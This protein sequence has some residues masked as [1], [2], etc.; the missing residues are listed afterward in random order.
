M[1]GTILQICLNNLKALMLA[2]AKLVDTD[3][4]GIAG[5]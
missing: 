5:Y 4:M 1:N 2:D 3:R